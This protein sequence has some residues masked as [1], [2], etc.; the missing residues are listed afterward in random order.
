MKRSLIVLAMFLVLLIVSACS[1]QAQQYATKNCTEIGGSISYSSTTVVTDG[2][3]DS[4]STSF[5]QFMPVVN[6]YVTNNLFLGI[7]PGINIFK[8]AGADNSLKNYSLFLVPGYTFSSRGTVFPFIEGMIGY[9]ALSQDAEDEEDKIDLSGLS[10]G[11]KGGIK[12]SVGSGG[13][14]SIGASYI[15]F[16]L[17]PKGASKRSGYNNLALTLGFSVFFGR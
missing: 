12:V 17:S 15:A 7:S 14:A 4:K 8:P 3:A 11:A 6:Y 9:T 16:N 5:L 13:L 1:I 10:L 2:T